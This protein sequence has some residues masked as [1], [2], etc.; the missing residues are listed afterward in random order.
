MREGI[1]EDLAREVTQ[2]ACK[3]IERRVIRYMQSVGPYFSGEDSGLA[4]AWDEVCVQVQ[5]QESFFWDLYVDLMQDI[6]DSELKRL[7]PAVRSAIW[8]QTEVWDCWYE[9]DDEPDMSEQDI[10]WY[11]CRKYVL[12]AAADWNNARIQDYIRNGLL[13]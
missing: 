2:N 10:N 5:V 1:L 6:I 4:N 12:S 3:L 11:L 13:D 8:L 9:E 7:S